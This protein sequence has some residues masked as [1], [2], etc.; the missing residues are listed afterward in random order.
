MYTTNH[1]IAKSLSNYIKN[2]PLKFNS[3][4]SKLVDKFIIRLSLDL[5]TEEIAK[6]RTIYQFIFMY[7]L[8]THNLNGVHKLIR[9][10]KAI[11]TIIEM[12]IINKSLVLRQDNQ[13]IDVMMQFGHQHITTLASHHAI[14]H[15]CLYFDVS[16]FYKAIKYM[17]NH[18]C[19]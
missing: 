12:L 16:A 13:L 6:L 15:C 17:A 3:C 2:N 11:I 1:N 5:P 10:S 19:S 4:T 14:T 7:S 8:I 9:N 18:Y